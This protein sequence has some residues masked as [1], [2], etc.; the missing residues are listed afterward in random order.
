MLRGPL[1]S[2]F[3]HNRFGT[4]LYMKGVVSASSTCTPAAVPGVNLPLIRNV[5]G[6]PE[7]RSIGVSLGS[8]AFLLMQKLLTVD[9]Q[10][11]HL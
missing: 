4:E 3:T 9:P 8:I 7:W 2:V 1:Y 5:T 6:A 11:C 10:V